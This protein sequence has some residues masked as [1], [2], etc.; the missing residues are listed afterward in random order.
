MSL[1][2]EIAN[3][4]IPL[5]DFQMNYTQTEIPTFDITIPTR[6]IVG[7]DLYLEDVAIYRDGDLIIEGLIKSPYVYPELLPSIANPL[8]TSLKCD[9]NLGRLA[10]EAGALIHF[11]N[12][13]VSV[14]IATLLSNAQLSNWILN[15]T[16]TL[17]DIEVTVDVREK[18][19][20][21]SQ[22]MEICAQSRYATFVRYN[23]FS[24]GNHLL[25][26]GYFRERRNTPKAAWGDNILEPPR[27]QE[28]S[29]EPIKYLYPVSGSSSDTPVS[30]DDALNI[31]PTLS[32]GTQDYQILVGTGS[33]RNNTITKGCALRRSFS[34]IKTENDDAPTQAELNEAA[35]ALYRT[36]A[37]EMEASQSS[38]SITV[39]ITCEEPPQ[40]H[41]AIWLESKIFEE[42]YDLYTEQFELIE[43]FDL[44][45]YFRITGISADLR[46]RFEVW[47]PYTEQYVGNAVYELELVEGD[48]RI[49]KSETD[50]LIDK[51]QNTGIYDN[52]EGIAGGGIIGV[53]TV[54]VQHDTVAP[55]CNYS[56]PGT[57]KTFTFTIPSA[58]VG[59]T[60]VI[61]TVK[62]V[63][64]SNYNYK[65][66]TY[67][68]IGGTHEL[69]VQ[70]E[71]TS[72]WDITDDCT[73][74]ISVIF[75]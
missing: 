33:I 5:R 26:L 32:A 43:S 68:T 45:G 8:F 58:P 20:L 17:N 39:K 60:D 14:A 30:L 54:T 65:T 71:N 75:T 67:G 63:S 25:D 49:V 37:E 61:V 48:K 36:A 13:L 66:T 29:Q 3:R 18:E 15:D 34:S 11:Q 2:A 23:S 47:N 42:G 72:D 21:W 56:G 53:A 1:V 57:G 31:D 38:A 19:T 4:A 41:D 28:A 10:I 70:N 62:S 9:N 59:A 44:S 24:G 51:T 46:E 40:I 52:I 22:I 16:T 12:T 64:P 69:C 6:D 7:L 35:I 55:D 27:F 74:I 73:I 50:I